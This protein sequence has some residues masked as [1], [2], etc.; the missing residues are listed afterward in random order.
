M[1]FENILKNNPTR[2]KKKIWY[3][4]LHVIVWTSISWMSA[5]FFLNNDENNLKKGKKKY[6]LTYYLKV[7]MGNV[8]LVS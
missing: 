5:V 7:N 1:L 3:N 8:S 2:E 6:D 4:I